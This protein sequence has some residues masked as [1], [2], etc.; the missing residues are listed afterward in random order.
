MNTSSFI[1]QLKREYWE[2]KAW[3]ILLPTIPAVLI[4]LL[5]ILVSQVGEF[6]QIE[7]TPSIPFESSQQPQILDFSIDENSS[8]SDTDEENDDFNVEI[9]VEAN[10]GARIDSVLQLLMAV[11]WFNAFFYFLSCLY[12]DRKDSSILFW[13]SLPVSDTQQVLSKFT[14]GMVS[15]PMVSMAIGWILM[16]VLVVIDNTLIESSGFNLIEELEPNRNVFVDFIVAPF[17]LWGLTALKFFPLVAI[18][19]LVSAVSKRSPFLWLIFPL[20]IIS[21]IERI[22]LHSNNLLDWFLSHLPVFETEAFSE[23]SSD[24]VGFMDRYYF[25]GAAVLVRDTVL[26]VIIIA[27]CIWLRK[28]RF[29]I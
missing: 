13:K 2:S 3:L 5:I 24:P 12:S 29:E 22:F 23:I 21:I 15:F 6:A 7:T 4:T 25:Y 16:V 19:M 8:T 14:F 20:F 18:A 1:A 27:L 26:S 17:V 10:G 11:G 9:N 28:N